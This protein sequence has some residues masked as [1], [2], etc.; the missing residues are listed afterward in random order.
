LLLRDMIATSQSAGLD[1]C[2][3]NKIKKIDK[4]DKY[5]I[6][7]GSKEDIMAENI[8]ICCAEG[9]KNFSQTKVKTSYAPIAVVSGLSDKSESFVELDYFPKNCINVLVK[10]YG[11]GLV[12]GISLS[13]KSDCDAYLDYVIKQHKKIDPN[14]TEESR[15]IGLKTEVTFKNQPRGYLYHIVNLDEGIW[16]L[17]PG[18]FTLAFSMAPEFYRRIYKK[19][20]KKHFETVIDY[21]DNAIVSNTV[22]YD[23]T[24]AIINKN[25]D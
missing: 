14:I 22:W 25:E 11:I 10:D 1:I 19:N 6:L 16:T 15:Y 5:K 18:K 7:I 8:A 20:P 17:I 21:D 12:G 9:L 24:K 23:D 13:K 4:S 3:N 2:L